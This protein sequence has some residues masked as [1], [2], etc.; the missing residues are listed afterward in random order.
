MR[1]EDVVKL[2]EDLWEAYC[3]K[4]SRPSECWRSLIGSGRKM[5]GRSARQSPGGT[6]PDSSKL[7]ACRVRSPFGGL[8][9]VPA[10]GIG[11]AL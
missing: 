5:A 8:G 6:C 9:H 3:L 4:L 11:F 10:K 2:P 7:A 1:P